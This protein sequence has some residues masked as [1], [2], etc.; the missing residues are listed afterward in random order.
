MILTTFIVTLGLSMLAKD[1]NIPNMNECCCNNSPEQNIQF[2]RSL[3]KM[4]ASPFTSLQHSMIPTLQDKAMPLLQTWLS[5]S[6]EKRVN[7]HLELLYRGTETGCSAYVFH[8]KCD[9]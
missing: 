9:G 1:L 3:N 7:F 8:K 4:E 5:G 2:S 6:K